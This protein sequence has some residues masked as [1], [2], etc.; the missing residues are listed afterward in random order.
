MPQTLLAALGK[1]GGEE[2]LLSHQQGHLARPQ[3]REAQ[4]SP[5][6]T[7]NPCTGV[8][9]GLGSGAWPSGPQTPAKGLL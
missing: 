1:G 2:E 4:T 7:L 5:F 8:L 9:V 3:G 6:S